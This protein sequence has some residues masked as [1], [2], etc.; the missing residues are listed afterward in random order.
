MLIDL[1]RIY[2]TGGTGG[3]GCQSL[4]K[5]IF[6]RKG[7]PDGGDG[8]D[9]GNVVL[10]ST[11]DLQTLL[12][13]KYRQ[14]HKAGNGK[15]GGSNKKNG[16][17]GGKWKVERHELPLKDVFFDRLKKALFL[18]CARADKKEQE[19][20]PLDGSSSYY[21]AYEKELGGL[22]RGYSNNPMSVPAH[23]IEVS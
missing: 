17:P 3:K 19:L 4:Y 14:H 6:H 10:V 2:V 8:G 18:L 11:T 22:K 5:D 21:Q 9:G 7:V 15:H 1:A 12:D 16:K 13:Y 23:N 20:E